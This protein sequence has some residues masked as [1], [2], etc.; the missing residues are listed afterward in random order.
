MNKGAE[1]PSKERCL[2]ATKGTIARY[3]FRAKDS[4]CKGS[5]GRQEVQASRSSPSASQAQCH[6]DLRAQGFTLRMSK[7]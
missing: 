4:Q 2:H 3:P 7:Y 5:D 1:I 6:K